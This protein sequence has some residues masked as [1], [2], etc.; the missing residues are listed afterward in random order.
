[1]RAWF[2]VAISLALGSLLADPARAQEAE[3]PPVVV[4]D[5]GG[6]AFRIALQEF[7]PGARA[8]GRSRPGGLSRNSVSVEDAMPS[9]QNPKKPIA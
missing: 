5:A 6:K 1:M 9:A 4:T 3:R 8:S 2:A 7:A